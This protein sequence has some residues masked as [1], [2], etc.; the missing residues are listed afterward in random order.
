[1]APPRPAEDSRW[2]FS[3]GVICLREASRVGGEDNER[4]VRGLGCKVR[5]VLPGGGLVDDIV[6]CPRRT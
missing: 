3:D 5:R 4:I 2:T 6:V 1:M